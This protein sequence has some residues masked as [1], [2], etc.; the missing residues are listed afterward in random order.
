MFLLLAAGNHVQAQPVERLGIP[1]PL[2]FDKVP[3]TLAWTSRPS[4]NYF[5]QE[6]L[7]AGEHVEDFHQM[8]TVHLTVVD[9]AL[10]DAVSLKIAELKKRR[11]DDPTCNYAVEQNADSTEYMIDFVVTQSK[12]D[13]I[14]IAEFNVY[15]YREVIVSGGKR[16]V[17][18]VA[19]SKRAYGD[20]ADKFYE[21]LNKIRSK[22]LNAMIDF[23]MPAVN[24]R[25]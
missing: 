7:P 19:Y 16:A 21:R 9:I 6:Y 3:F 4:D 23:G 8:L 15:R 18:V 10:A 1:G 22:Y 17:L 24:I 20:E 13:M 11:A 25:Q 5:I 14:E 2:R 12:D